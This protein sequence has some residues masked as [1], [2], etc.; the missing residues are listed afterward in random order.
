MF[1]LTEIITEAFFPVIKGLLQI[2]GK[3][4]RS[5]LAFL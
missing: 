4:S 3:M 2:E 5:L 1:Y